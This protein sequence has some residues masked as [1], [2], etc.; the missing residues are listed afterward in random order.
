MTTEWRRATAQDA[1]LL[2]DLADQ[3]VSPAQVTA[4]LQTWR[5]EISADNE[6]A[7]AVLPPAPGY[8]RGHGA[9][10]GRLGADR[11]VQ[12]A[13]SVPGLS[14]LQ[15]SLPADKTIDDARFEQADQLVRRRRFGVGSVGSGVGCDA[16]RSW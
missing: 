2:A 15:V 6:A 4:F 14:V 13:R 9:W 1:A 8:S 7:V 3:D 5:V 12:L 10:W 11:L 16:W